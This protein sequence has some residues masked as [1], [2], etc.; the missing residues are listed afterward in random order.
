MLRHNWGMPKHV[1]RGLSHAHLY[2][3]ITWRSLSRLL[4]QNAE[5]SIQSLPLQAHIFTL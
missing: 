1:S 3:L 2:A 5:E 4:R